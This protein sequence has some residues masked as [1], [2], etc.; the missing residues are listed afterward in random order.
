[1]N[2]QATQGFR[3][4]FFFLF[5]ICCA[6]NT[7]YTQQKPNIIFVL[8]DDLGYSDIGVYGNP[9]IATPFLDSMA[10][11][12]VR[13]THYV[14]INPTCTPS[15]AGLLTG[16]Y[17]TRYGL[18]DPIGP[19]SKLGLPP[20]E[21]TIA[22]L[23][24]TVGYN[25]ATIGK[26]HLGDRPHFHPNT[27][28]FDS[29]FGMLYS[30]DYRSPY[31]QTDTTIKLFHNH[32]VLTERPEDSSLSKIYHEKALDFIRDQ[33]DAQPFFLYYA[34]NM[35]HLPVARAVNKIQGDSHPAGPLGAVI[36]ELDQSLGHL[37]EVLQ[38]RGLAD[39]TIFIFSSDNG[40]WIE[41]PAR[42]E[43]D[44]VTKNWHVGTAGMFRGSK[45]QSH[46][47]GVRVPFILNGAPWTGSAQTV[48][49]AMSNLD[50]LPTIMDW[51]GV[52]LPAELTLDGQSLAPLLKGEVSDQQFQHRPIYI[53][54]HGKPEAVKVGDWKYR[55]LEAGINNNSGKAYPASK[56]LFHV[57]RDPSERTN[58]IE[59]YPAKA[60][61]LKKL[62]DSF[63]A[64]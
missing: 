60:K 8:T 33:S 59:E 9:S 62:F 41:Y 10:H 57:G 13:A 14:V 55:E 26:W 36:E 3:M 45:A 23:L 35:P 32:R 53:V 20:E 51:A 37:W 15:R 12:G 40:P 56:E 27:Q 29:F 47:G 64:Y 4:L 43:G 28:G 18:S 30:H 21:V 17:P 58:I 7:A 1:M 39:N 24:K 16:R 34:H 19:G 25:T 49:S 38:E 5:T 2:P 61:E 31:V 11:T 42:M 6:N 63:D 54:N 48:R 22:E 44:Q 52:R 46:E 50:V